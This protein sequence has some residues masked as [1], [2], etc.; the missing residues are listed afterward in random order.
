MFELVHVPLLRT[1]TLVYNNFIA[2][3]FLQNSSNIFFIGKYRIMAHNVK[4]ICL[5]CGRTF[6]ARNGNWAFCSVGCKRLYNNHIR[7]TLVSDVKNVGMLH[8]QYETIH[9]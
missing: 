1:C 5:N 4:R 6:V 9:L 7:I 8:A 3:L 2:N